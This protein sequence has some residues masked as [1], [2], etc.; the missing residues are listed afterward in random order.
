MQREFRLTK[1]KDFSSVQRK[2]RSQANRLLILR[3][4]NNGLSVSRFGFSVGRGVGTAV[5]RNTLKR[6]LRAAVQSIPVSAGWDVVVIAR[7]TAASHSFDELRTALEQLLGRAG[8][9][10]TEAEE[11]LEK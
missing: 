11:P 3:V 5:T 10:A 6:R 4:L 1:S 2:G 9:L 8:L 7:P